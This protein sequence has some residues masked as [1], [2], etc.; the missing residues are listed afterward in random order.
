MITPTG[1]YIHDSDS[2]AMDSLS[3]ILQDSIFRAVSFSG[4]CTINSGPVQSDLLCR[5]IRFRSIKQIEENIASYCSKRSEILIIYSC[6][7]DTANV[8]HAIKNGAFDFIKFPFKSNEIISTLHRARIHKSNILIK[9]IE[10]SS[11]TSRLTR[12][13]L[14]ENQILG[15]IL[16]GQKNKFIAFDLSISQRTVENHRASI[17]KKMEANSIIELVSIMSKIK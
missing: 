2:E 16:K 6:R 4:H 3:L 13:T 7:N 17:M 11:I 10:K 1:I 15:R 14:R 8:V 9:E 12:L 5:L